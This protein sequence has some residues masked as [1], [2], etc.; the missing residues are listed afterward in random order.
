M[1]LSFQ[2][3][4]IEKGFVLKEGYSWDAKLIDGKKNGIVIVK[5]EEEG[6]V[7]NVLQ[8]ENDKL[9]GIC[10]FYDVGTL[11]EKRTFVNDIAEGWAWRIEFDDEVECIMYNNGHKSTRLE[12]CNDMDNY[13]KAIDIDSNDIVSVCC[14]DENHNPIGKGYIFENG[15]IKRVVMFENGK[16]KEVLKSFNEDEMIVFDNG[17]I[18]YKG[19]FS[20]DLSKDYP[21]EGIGKEY[22]GKLLQYLGEWKNNKREG[23]GKTLK[24]GFAEY[25]GEWKDGLPNGFG[26]LK[27]DGKSYIGNWVM[28]SL[29]SKN[30]EMYDYVD[31][32]REIVKVTIANEDQLRELLNNVDKNRIVKGLVIDEGCGNEMKDGLELCGFENLESIVVKK[33]SLKNLKSL[34][35]SNNPLLKSIETEDG[36][37]A[38]SHSS[39][40]GAFLNVKNVTITSTLI[41]D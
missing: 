36:D 27:R 15:K 9:N 39:N 23:R 28:G 16:E 31:N 33:G 8:Y 22:C 18:V 1:N 12:R 19:C 25:E 34:K 6:W 32:R 17:S 38:W 21:R 35:I 40:A 7:S 2:K 29:Y 5:N 10:E 30:G 41:D 37:D 11:V 3:D 4:Q 20:D 24:D 26:L 14:Y 13:W